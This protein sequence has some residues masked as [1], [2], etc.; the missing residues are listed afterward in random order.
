MNEVISTS[1]PFGMKGDRETRLGPC[2][3]VTMVTLL[4]PKPEHCHIVTGPGWIALTSWQ[5]ARH[6]TWSGL[7]GLSWRSS[8]FDC[9]NLNRYILLASDNSPSLGSPAMHHHVAHSVRHVLNLGRLQVDQ[10][11]DPGD[12]QVQG[13]IFGSDVWGMPALDSRLTG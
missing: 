1:W 6:P 8:D 12:P 10:T 11:D 3:M 7:Y 5:A 9:L 2:V 13:V 4:N